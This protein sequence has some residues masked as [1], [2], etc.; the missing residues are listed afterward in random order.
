MA[1][2]VDLAEALRRVQ[3]LC[4]FLEVF[5]VPRNVKPCPAELYK[6]RKVANKYFDHAHFRSK[7]ETASDLACLGLSLADAT[8]GGAKEAL[9]KSR[10]AR[11]SQVIESNPGA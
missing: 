3:V 1:T 11:R 7:R 6:I 9:W 10:N 4:D 2:S 8:D 5:R